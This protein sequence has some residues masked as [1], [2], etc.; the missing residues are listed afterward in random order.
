MG[1]K[2]TPWCKQGKKQDKKQNDFI[3]VDIEICKNV[4]KPIQ[5]IIVMGQ[6]EMLQ[7]ILWLSS[8]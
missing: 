1:K 8:I 6:G 5:T 4:L 3:Y 7:A 2:L